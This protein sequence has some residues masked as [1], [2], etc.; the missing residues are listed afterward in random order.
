MDRNFLLTVLSVFLGG[1]AVQ[2]L[3]FFVRRKS[4][5]KA[6]DRTSEASMLSGASEFTAQLQARLSALDN[7]NSN[8]EAKL[9]QL[10]ERHEV[11]RQELID[12]MKAANREITRLRNA[13]IRLETELHIALGHNKQLQEILKQRN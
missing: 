4:D 12:S 13:V 3:I 6:L 11:E 9:V 2:L 8:M 1:G 10:N 7:T 5:I